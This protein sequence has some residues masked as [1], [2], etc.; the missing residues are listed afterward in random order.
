MISVSQLFQ[1]KTNI[2]MSL[3]KLLWSLY[4]N[5]I[6]SRHFYLR[7]SL[8]KMIQFE[9]Y[10]MDERIA[11]DIDE[12]TAMLKSMTS[13]SYES[14][15]MLSE[16]GI[17]QDP[18]ITSQASMESQYS[19]PRPSTPSRPSQHSM[20]SHQE[21]DV[22][23]LAAIALMECNGMLN[24]NEVNAVASATDKWREKAGIRLGF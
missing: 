19:I 22:P 21:T 16:V 18:A 6:V 1:N 10:K 8:L 13:G 24:R 14:E 2:E 11:E 9:K 17:D 23:E 7:Q 20:A 4:Y 5:K 3:E 12:T 15:T